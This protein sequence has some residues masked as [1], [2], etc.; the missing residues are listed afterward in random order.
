M[1]VVVYGSLW[2][3]KDLREQVKNAMFIMLLKSFISKK[4]RAQI[5]YKRWHIKGDKP[6]RVEDNI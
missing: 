3:H 5:G 4:L 2:L 6:G 1:P